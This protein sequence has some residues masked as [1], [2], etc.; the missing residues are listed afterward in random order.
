MCVTCKYKT[1]HN[2]AEK[3]KRQRCELTFIV[4]GDGC[5]LAERKDKAHPTIYALGGEKN[6]DAERKHIVCD[7]DTRRIIS[8]ETAR[9]VWY[10]K[11]IANF[12]ACAQ[13]INK[14]IYVIAIKIILLFTAPTC[15]F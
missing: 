4:V 14:N 15:L 3:I 1:L 9:G 8:T 2:A 6:V 11:K 7:D 12:E 10:E 5:V 13:N